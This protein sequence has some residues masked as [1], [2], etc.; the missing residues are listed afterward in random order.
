MSLFPAGHPLWS[1][2]NFTPEWIYNIQQDKVSNPVHQAQTLPAVMMA[3]TNIPQLIMPGR[4][5]KHPTFIG[6]RGQYV[7]ALCLQV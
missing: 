3:P 4:T 6:I 5:G 1:D 7:K 2:I